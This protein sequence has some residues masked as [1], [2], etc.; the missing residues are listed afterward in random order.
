MSTPGIHRCLPTF[1]IFILVIAS[2]FSASRDPIAAKNGM[3]VSVDGLASQVGIDILRKGG[4]AVDAAVAVGFALAVVHPGAGNIGGGGFMVIHMDRNGEETTLDYRETAPATASREMY[5]DDNGK[6]IPRL[7]TVG[8]KAV[9]VPGSVRGLNEAW[10]KYGQLK[11]EELVQPA[12]ELA[13][14]GFPAS[15]A[16]VQSLKEKAI[17]DKLSQFPESKRIFLNNGNFYSEGDLLVQK[18]LGATLRRISHQGPAGFYEGPVAEATV[19]E[20][21]KHGGLITLSDLKN[22]QVRF[23]SPIRGSYRGYEIISMGPPSSGGIALIEML[24]MLERFPV[25]QLGFA[26]SREIHL[27]AEIMRRAF[28]DRAEFLGDSDFVKVPG[29]GLT[30]K[31][32]AALVSSGISGDYASPSSVVGHG[33]PAAYESPETTHYSVVDKDDNAVAVTT[34]LNDSYGSGVTVAGAGFLLNDEMDDF[35]S[36]PGVPNMF[37]L[38]QGEA[39]AIAPKKR[40]LSAMT[41]TIVKKDNKL[42]IV[43][44][45]P[46]G[47]TIINTVFQVLVN[48]IDHRMNIQEAVDASRVHHQWLP[49]E[50]LVEK[51]GISR[52]VERALEG[53]GHVL[54]FRDKIGDAH[55]I[56]ID[57]QTRVRYGAADPRRSGLAVGY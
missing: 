41:P 35:T 54:K 56:L 4:N 38:I 55:S 57:P 28:A 51:D 46:G 36:K 16:L 9:A 34:T 32:Y 22:Y 27:K 3:V 11:W 47:P 17:A 37:K 14:K 1:V 19:K 8:H 31:E 29:K 7:S 49:D 39:N 5:L 43:T 13:E 2:P 48:V 20:M 30:S 45:S 12:I 52:D 44:G 10:K 26:S 21:E 53:K 50:L 42:F 33:K 40:P 6:V 18:E 25:A 24:N 23:R 15:A